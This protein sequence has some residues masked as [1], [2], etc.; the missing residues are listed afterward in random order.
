MKIT[1]LIQDAMRE[2]PQA[3]APVVAE[4][5]GQWVRGIPFHEIVEAD[6]ACERFAFDHNWP[7]MANNVLAQIH[8]RLEAAMSLLDSDFMQEASS[9]PVEEAAD[10]LLVKFWHGKGIEWADHTYPSSG[11]VKG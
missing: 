9:L 8:L 2:L 7:P 6:E 5:I 1:E 10:I 4:Q 11:H 3:E